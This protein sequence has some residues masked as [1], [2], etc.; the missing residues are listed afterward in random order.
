MVRCFALLL[1]CFCCVPARANED[2]YYKLTT[3]PIP[4]N[5]KLEVSGLTSMPDGRIA[6]AIRRGEIWIIENVS[7]P[8]PEEIQFH[9][10]A[11]GLHEPLGLAYRDGCFYTA[12]RTELTRL[13]DTDHDGRADEYLTVA[14]GWGVTG[15]YHE[16]AYGPV[17]DQSGNLWVTLNCTLGSPIGK[18]DAWRGWS[19]KI[20][21]SGEWSPV[22]GGLRSPCGIGLHRDGAI[23]ASEQQGNWF[24]AG[25]LVHLQ[26]GVFHGHADALKHC[27]RLGATFPHPGKIPENLT[28]AQAART[29][30]HYKPPAVWLPYRKMG[31]SATDVLGDTTGGKFG[32]FK[33]QI[34]V[35]E[36]TMSAL[37]R[38]S[39]E[40]V[41]GEYQG[42]C[43]PFRKGFQSGVL[44]LAWSND[45]SMLVGESNRGWNSLGTR[46][47]GL[48]R[49][50]W[51]GETPFEIETIKARRDGFLVRFTQP[52]DPESVLA[53]D[54]CR[55]SSYTYPYHSAYG[56]KELDGQELSL[57][58]SLSRNRREL[59][60]VV[61]NLRE[62]YVHEFSFSGIRSQGRPLLHDTA[63]YTLNQIP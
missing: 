15:N 46:A 37:N 9:P 12:Q 3:I 38:V 2:Q 56:G 29:I 16:Y 11:T 33:N 26:P 59:T 55:V 50:V 63:Y 35:G 10:F 42:A 52:A 54:A 14:K 23:F 51:S 19:L 36:F 58:T 44:R 28:V 24:A 7:S 32:P 47:Y 6:V 21:P 18:D 40:T 61:Q 13:R 17:F 4:E 31:M 34:F 60:L 20:K 53:T 25:G 1:A 49:L 41:K 57:K 62:G 45:G 39:L 5:L 22:S 8:A 48:Q 30:P 43:F 27:A